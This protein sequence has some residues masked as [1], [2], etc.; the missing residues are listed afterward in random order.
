MMTLASRTLTRLF[1]A[2][3]FALLLACAQ[4]DSAQTTAT[5]DAWSTD[6]AGAQKSAK[7]QNRPML[8]NFEGSDWCPPCMMLEKKVFSQKAFL[9]YAK[10]SLV[11][12]KLDFPRRKEQAEALKQQN[13]SLAEKF[14]VDAF[15]TVLLL[16]AAG[17]EKERLVGYDGEDAAGYVAMLKE[18]LAKP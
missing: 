10:E 14:Q 15:P 11:L 2:A 3:S 16:N 13:Q 12:V 4:A 1:C 5:L 6:F 9:D 7:E 17:E 18:K 8:V